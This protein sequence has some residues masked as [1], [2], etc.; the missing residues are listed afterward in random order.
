VWK[1]SYPG[2]ESEDDQGIDVRWFLDLQL[3]RTGEKAKWEE[4]GGEEEA[5][6]G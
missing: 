2:K 1:F 4:D 6:L 5:E 3:I